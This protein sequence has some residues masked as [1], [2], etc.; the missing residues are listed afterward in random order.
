MMAG[1]AAAGTD[2]VAALTPVQSSGWG[3]GA[4]RVV[5]PESAAPSAAGV[6]GEPAAGNSGTDKR[7]VWSRRSVMWHLHA[8]VLV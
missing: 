3:T 2:P 6:S 4:N 1:C 7:L 8:V 5:E